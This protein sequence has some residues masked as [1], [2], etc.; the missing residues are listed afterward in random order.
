MTIDP[1]PGA[2][3]QRPFYPNALHPV[4][5]E[6]IEVAHPELVPTRLHR[7]TVVAFAAGRAT[8]TVDSLLISRMEFV[9]TG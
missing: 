9:N 4:D 8:R 1:L 5:R 3:R 7:W 2:Q 6:V